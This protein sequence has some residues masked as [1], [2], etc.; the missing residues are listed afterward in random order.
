MT[1]V[2][3]SVLC[4]VQFPHQGK[5]ITIV[6]LDF[7]TFDIH[8]YNTKNVP[9]LGH[10][11]PQFENKGVGHLKDSPIIG[12]FSEVPHLVSMVNMIKLTI[13]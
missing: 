13:Q 1:V 8:S 10:F 4:L 2:A 5:I 9:L 6:Q 3:S 11:K 7:F 12:F